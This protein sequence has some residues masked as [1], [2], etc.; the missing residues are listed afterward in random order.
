MPRPAGRTWST[1]RRVPGTPTDTRD[2]VR[3]HLAQYVCVVGMTATIEQAR[4]ADNAPR[5][6]RPMHTADVR[7]MDAEAN[8][9][10]V[11]V[12]ITAAPPA[13]PITE[14]LTEADAHTCREYGLGSSEHGPSA[15]R[16]C[17][18]CHGAGCAPGTPAQRLWQTI[19]SPSEPGAWRARKGWTWSLPRGNFQERGGE[20][21]P[22][23]LLPRKGA[24]FSAKTP[25]RSGVDSVG[26]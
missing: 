3:D 24:P 26:P 12:V 22:R 16:P 17:P 13:R 2:E 9:T 20:G 4:P 7:V 6:A 10:W 21:A 19:S 25:L 11:D 5:H 14:R 18:L 23:P 15:S 1:P 8:A